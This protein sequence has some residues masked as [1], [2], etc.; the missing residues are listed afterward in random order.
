MTHDRT[1]L[2]T[3]KYERSDSDRYLV[4]HARKRAAQRVLL[5]GGGVNTRCDLAPPASIEVLAK[6]LLDTLEDFYAEIMHGRAITAQCTRL[7]NHND[8]LEK[9]LRAKGGPRL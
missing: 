5:K 6:M 3:S 9:E 2:P 4:L 8:E 7:T 1:P